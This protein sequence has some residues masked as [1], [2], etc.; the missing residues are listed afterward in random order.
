VKHLPLIVRNLLRNRRRTLLTILSMGVSVFIFA[1]LVSLPAVVNQILRDSASSLRVICHN[2][3]GFG[4]PLPGA[5]EGTIRSFRHVDAVTGYSVF[6]GTYRDP[7]VQVPAAALEPDALRAIWPEWDVSAE[8]AA[9][10]Q[11]DRIACLVSADLMRQY[12]W[13]AG[14]KIIL[15]G[16]SQAGDL[17]LTI[18]GAL[19]GSKT[20]KGIILFRRDY[21]DELNG[22]TGKVI[23]FFI[24]VDRSDAIP[25]LIRAIDGRFANSSFETETE[26]EVNVGREQVRSYRLLFRGAEYF[27]AIVIFV[28]GL[29]AANT[30]AM[31]VRER[32]SEIAVM[33]S[34]GYTRRAMLALL[35]AE[36]AAIGI[37][38]GA[39]GCVLA[40]AVLKVLAYVSSGQGLFP[41]LKL[42]PQVG[43]ES[44][45]MAML[46]GV[47][48]AAIPA[49]IATR[50]DIASELRAL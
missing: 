33:R 16:V 19:R 36:G 22:A 2:K 3:A 4:Y 35:V 45:G 34:I 37:A 24:K 13:K 1:A 31:A 7:R 25:D 23:V 14:D 30:A 6:V 46:I 8:S 28:I 49:L 9:A 40:W 48:S 38:G 11:R 17:E 44:F 32:R 12:R 5:Y 43:V 29:V 41:L 15:H 21:F 47:G 20:P 26:S 18:V 39:I 42:L 27:A 50:G 10:L